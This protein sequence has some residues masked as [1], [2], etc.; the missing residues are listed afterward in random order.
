MDNNLPILVMNMWQMDNLIN[1]VL[2][3]QVGTIISD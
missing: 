2:G 1:A 3:K